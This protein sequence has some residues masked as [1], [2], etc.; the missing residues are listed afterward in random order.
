MVKFGWNIL[1]IMNVED[2]DE[3][4]GQIQ[5]QEVGPDGRSRLRRARALCPHGTSRVVKW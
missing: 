1:M 3:V 5:I 2:V 4:R